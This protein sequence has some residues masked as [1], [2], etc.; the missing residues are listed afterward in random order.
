MWFK[1][2][3]NSSEVNK[4]LNRLA[5]QSFAMLGLIGAARRAFVLVEKTL[6]QACRAKDV[7]AERC[8]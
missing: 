2:L 6:L 5:L 1:G 8:R 7:T 4:Q 3:P